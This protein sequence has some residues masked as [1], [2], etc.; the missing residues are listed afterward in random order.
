MMNQQSFRSSKM[1]AIS[2]ISRYVRFTLGLKGYLKKPITLEQSR[3]IIKKRLERRTDVFLTIIKKAVYENKKSPYLKLLKLFGCEY[4]DIESLVRMQGI[5]PSL[6]KL[7][8]EGIWLSLGQFKGREEVAR[9][10]KTFKFNESD[11]DNPYFSRS[12]EKHDYNGKKA[13]IRTIFDLDYLS[14]EAVCCPPIFAAN[15]VLETPF[16]MWRPALSLGGET[17]LL[18]FAK[19]GIAPIKWFS[20]VDQMA[21][22]PSLKNRMLTDYLVYLGRLLGTSW[23]N[24][25]HVTLDNAEKITHWLVDI[26]KQNGKCCIISTPSNALRICNVAKEEGYDLD[27]VKFIVEAEPLSEAKLREIL[28]TGATA[29]SIYWNTEVGLIGGSCPDTTADGGGVHLAKDS[30]AAIQ[31]QRIVE[32]AGVSVNAFLFSSLLFAAPRIVFNIESEDYGLIKSASCGC[33]LQ[34]LGLTDQI[35]NIR[36]FGWFRAE[37]TRIFGD[38]LVKVIEYILPAKFGGNPS[39]Y[40][41]FEEEDEGGFTRV[42]VVVS[43]VVGPIEEDALKEEILCTLRRGLGY[44]RQETYRETAEFWSQGRTL[45]VRRM[46]P[47]AGK[48]L[49][50]LQIQSNK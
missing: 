48:K 24:P 50:P 40:Q 47:T 41:M 26:L 38:D 31:H 16:A 11:F 22:R 29:L 28:L 12:Y 9:G 23:S 17:F 3:E 5:E 4:G 34:H 8:N 33:E 15:H 1:F 42:V 2:D 10:G 13:G 35:S 30:M 6:K 37:G 25:R 14:Q 43:P 21:I 46:L 7:S 49:L 32:N 20:Q 39:D 45:Q 44:H 27:G 36:S 19:A 18:I